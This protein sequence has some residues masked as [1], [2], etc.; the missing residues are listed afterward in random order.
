[1]L[2]CLICGAKFSRLVRNESAKTEKVVRL[3]NLAQLYEYETT[4]AKKTWGLLVETAEFVATAQLSAR[5]NREE[6]CRP[7]N[8]LW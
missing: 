2:A 7:L 5:K 3:E 1:M 6:R 8:L 4:H